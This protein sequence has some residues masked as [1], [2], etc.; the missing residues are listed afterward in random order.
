MIDDLR[1]IVW[2][3]K[4]F[5][6]HVKKIDTTLNKMSPEDKVGC[7]RKV[8]IN[9]AMTEA[10][11]VKS[12]DHIGDLVTKLECAEDKNNCQQQELSAIKKIL[13]SSNI[14][15]EPKKYVSTSLRVS[16]D[17]RVKGLK[18]FLTSS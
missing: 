14:K 13:S 16:E 18:S 2:K 15:Y 17:T 1:V 11:L 6:G 5:Q 3:D 8:V 10:I 4:G 9:K 12:I 7:L